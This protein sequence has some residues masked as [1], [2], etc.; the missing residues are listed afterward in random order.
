MDLKTNQHKKVR[1][2]IEYVDNTRSKF[3][4]LSLKLA[5]PFN[6]RQFDSWSTWDLLII[7]GKPTYVLVFTEMNG[8][9]KANE[10]MCQCGRS[11]YK[12]EQVKGDSRGVY[13]VE[14]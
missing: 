7:D 1:E 2:S 12:K 3:E 5:P 8:H 6:Y 10:T 13:L 9:P 14:W 4:S 11:K